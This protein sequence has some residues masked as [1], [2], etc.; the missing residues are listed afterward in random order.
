RAPPRG[1]RPTG[2]PPPVQVAAPPMVPM[3]ALAPPPM[4]PPAPA[5]KPEAPLPA[6]ARAA[7]VAAPVDRARVGGGRPGRPLTRKATAR[8]YKRMAPRRVYP[9]LVVISGGEVRALAGQQF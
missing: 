4:A 8:Y 5:K 2:A 3:P 1:A 9:L 7:P 6:P